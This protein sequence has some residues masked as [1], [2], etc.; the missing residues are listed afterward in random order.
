M[1]NAGRTIQKREGDTSKTLG[2]PNGHGST[3]EFAGTPTRCYGLVMKRDVSST[4]NSDNIENACKACEV[5]RIS[6]IESKI[7]GDGNSGD[8]EIHRSRTAGF[9][10]SGKL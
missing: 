2:S 1:N 7:L 4:S 6:R 9:P 5:F 3:V 10:A 8:E